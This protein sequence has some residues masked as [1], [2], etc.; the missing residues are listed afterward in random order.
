MNEIPQVLLCVSIDAVAPS[1]LPSLFAAAGMAV[2][3]VSP[4]EMAVR[5]SRFVSDYVFGG[6][7]PTT[8]HEALES[9]LAQFPDRYVRVIVGDEPLL[10]TFLDV[11]ASGAMCKFIPMLGDR[12]LLLTML[13][14]VEFSRHA[15]PA[16][17][18]VPGDLLVE[19]LDQLPDG[20]VD[21]LPF[22]LK[23]KESLAGSGVHIVAR[24]DDLDEA[25]SKVTVPF[26]IQDFVGGRV[27]ATAVLFQNGQPKCW[28]SYYLC[29]Q[30]PNPTASSSAIEVCP[31]PEIETILDRIGEMTNFDGLCG[32]DWVQDTIRKRIVVLELN[33]RPTP[34]IHF[35]MLAGVSFPAAIADW[36]AGGNKVQ[37]PSNAAPPLAR[38]YPQH[39]H[40]AIQAG[41]P[42]EFFKTFADAPEGD[43]KLTLSHL[44]RTM[45]HYFPTSWRDRLRRW[46]RG[47]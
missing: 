23:E 42:W 9:H 30:W 37:R 15:G 33:P 4:P 25:I 7:S 16:G 34:G 6:S 13:S 28:F 10:R 24:P 17:I 45:T 35:G 11:P 32:I 38:M 29:R 5:Q 12:N 19:R 44:R 18:P 39:L 2:T 1:Q 40:W 47:R 27:G 46:A 31:Q 41:K 22:V 43:L 36:I 26:L 3:V 21:R 14:K 20:L 8:V